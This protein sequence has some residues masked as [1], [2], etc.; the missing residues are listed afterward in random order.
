MTEPDILHFQTSDY[1]DYRILNHFYSVIYFTNPV[2]DN[3]YKRFVRDFI[4]YH[5][6][7]FCAAGKIVKLLQ[8]EGKQRG[9]NVDEE[10]AGGFS[11][12]HV[13]RGDLQYKEV[14]ISAEEWYNTT[15]KLWKP[16]EILYIATDEKNKTFFDPIAKHHDLRFLGDYFEE[17]GLGHLDSSLM[18][19]VEIAVTSRGRVF[20]GTWHSTFSGYI[21]RLRGYYG[22]TK[23]SNYYSY[24]PRRFVMH[25]WTYPNGNYA[26]REFQ[27]AWLGIDGDKPILG[28]LEPTLASP[29]GPFNDIS[30]LG[31]PLHRPTHLARGV[32]GL[33]LPQTPA[34]MGA[35]RGRINCDVKVDS[36]AYWND[37]QGYTDRH[38]VSSFRPSTTTGH[39]Q[40]ITF[41]Q[42]AGRFNN[43]RM[44]MEIVMV[45]AGMCVCN[46]S[47]HFPSC[48]SKHHVSLSHCFR[49]CNGSHCC[50]STYPKPTL[51][52]K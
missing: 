12:L 7:V 4:H 33:P 36:L 44:S 27:S 21:I 43:I 32:S 39:Q 29:I 11:A 2:F 1:G 34:L 31:E 13:R 30:L 16:K 20:V 37:P 38:F 48:V 8:A 50:T 3:Y 14:I 26:A 25:K 42:D 49:S 5:D 47:V 46:T 45:F 15:A 24:K 17:A 9:F 10:G 51:R 18:G 41:W 28:D 35:S 40:Y 19:M 23:M 52:G 6:I 22:V